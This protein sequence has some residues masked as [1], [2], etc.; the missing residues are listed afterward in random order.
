MKTRLKLALAA[1]SVISI[2]AGAST[3][4][5]CVDAE[6]NVA[7]LTIKGK[8]KIAWNEPWHSA[9]SDG[10]F[11]GKEKAPYSEQKGYLRYELTDFYSSDDSAFYVALEALHGNQLKAVVYFDNDDHYEDETAFT[12][13]KQ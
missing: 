3:L 4:Y 10:S 8:N 5:S 1:L 13:T 6:G 2:Q 9:S 7:E 12:C 11:V